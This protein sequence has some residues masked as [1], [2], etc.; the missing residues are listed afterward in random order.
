MTE[1]KVGQRPHFHFQGTGEAERFRSTASATREP[2]FPQL[3]RASHGEILLGQLRSVGRV[4][5]EAVQYQRQSGQDGGFGLQIEFRSFPGFELAFEGLARGTQRIELLNLRR[6]PATQTDMATVFVPD[7]QL[8]AFESLVRQYLEANTTKGQPRNA[9][10]LN[11][12]QEIRFAAFSALWTDD[13]AVLPV[14]DDETIWWE[15]WLPVRQSREEVLNRFRS[16]ADASGFIT[17]NSA[18]MFPERTVLNVFASQ[19]AITQSILLLNEV[20]EIRRAKETAEFFDALAPAEQR[21]WA[22]ELLQRTTV[23]GN[24]SVRVCLLDTGVNPG[25]PLLAQHIGLND[26]YSVDP[27]WGLQDNVGHGT[28]LAGLALYGDLV[29]PLTSQAPITIRHRIESV[30]LLQAAVGNQNEPHGALTM[31]AVALPEIANPD[32]G[33]VFSMAITSIDARDR[34][35]PSAWSAAVDSLA[36]D[37]LGERANPRLIVISA[38]NADQNQALHYPNSNTTDG[39]HDPGQSWNALCVGAYTQKVTIDPPRPALQP[40][41]PAGG[42]SPYSTTSLTWQRTSWPLKPDV[43]FEGGNLVKD[44][45]AAYNYPSVSLLTTSHTPQARLFETSRAT[46]AASALAARMAAQ[47]S[48]SYPDFWPETVRALM[49]HSAEWTDRMKHDFLG[50][51]T[52]S[53]YE[54][55]VKTCGFGVPDLERALWSAGNSLTLILEDSLQPFIKPNKGNPTARDMHLH[56]LP[57]PKQELL[58]LGNTNVEMRVTLSYFVEPNPGVVERGIKGRYRYESHG[59]RFDVSRPTEER[60][61]FRYRINKRAR[62]EEE[63]AYLGGGSDPNWLLGTQTRHRGSLH[64]DIWRGTAAELADRGMIGIYPA[65]GWWKTMLKQGRCNDRVR[66]SL[67]VSIKTEQSDID[68]YA[69]IQNEIAARTAIANLV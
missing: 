41:A 40:V 33:R 23:A 50:A 26:L 69:A 5:S 11:P 68:L 63:G 27:A 42:L 65:L 46:S 45:L 66:Y 56:N 47:I 14:D 25:H 49:V 1:P 30:K 38:G 35:R 51:G 32:A 9:P 21:E 43:V 13:P 61:Q 44:N 48:S 58:N 39:I 17:S 22:N 53:D 4:M 7:G 67:V 10:L 12:I 16:I 57:W 3:D 59:L 52:K 29:G 2:R 20:A 36:S 60:D 31:S 64:S 55:L 62:D 34:G 6:D 18:L 19:A 37:V 28:G 15:F 24:G 54:R 8:K